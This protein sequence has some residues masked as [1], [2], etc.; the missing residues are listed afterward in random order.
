MKTIK[1][2]AGVA[3]ALVSMTSCND[4]LT[5]SPKDA[6]SPSSTWQTQDDASKFLVGCY[7]GWESSDLLLYLDAGSDYGFNNFSWEGFTNIGNGTFSASDPGWTLYGFGMIRRCNTFLDNVEKCSFSSDAVKNDMIAQAK[8]IRAWRYLKMETAYGGVPIIDNY[9]SADEAKVPRN[10]DQEVRDYIMK[11][12]N[13]ALTGI[14]DQ[15]S[16][17][18]RIAKG[19][20]LAMK[21]RASLYWG[22][23]Q[24]AKD[25][26]QQII[27]LGQY[28]LD[29]NYANVFTVAGQSSP[30]II[31]ACQNITGTYSLYTIGQLYNNGDGGWSSVVPT[32][33]LIDD[34]EMSN[35]L[36]K[37]EA[38]S[39]YDPT[40]PFHNRDPRMAMTV[41]YPGCE[42][43]TT[44][45]SNEVFNTLDEK[46]PNGT[47]NVNYPTYAD[48]ASKTSLT[49]AKYLAPASQYADM[50]DTQCCPIVFRYAEVLLTWAEA[51]NELNGPSTA[52]Y[53]KLDQIRQR[54]G[55]PKVDRAKYGT[56][57]ALRELI[58]RERGVE[59]AGEGIRRFDL[60][61]WKDNNGEMVAMKRL[62]GELKRV[63][64]TINY[65]ESDP[66]MRATITGTAVIENRQFQEYNKLFPIPQSSIDK[67][68]TLTQNPG[69]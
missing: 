29:P 60:V 43:T 37:E 21:M 15:P 17:R 19:A 57:E 47:N 49:W 32:Q 64:G 31:L 58:R 54:V 5:T 13:E 10:T 59:F 20:V 52:V 23:Y 26:A 25:A 63:T 7:D 40:H 66:T 3:V 44:G 69:Y 51:E 9:S 38:G 14:A 6:L 48:N 1:Y 33:N 68:T 67:N 11:N 61:R 12:L 39:G 22:E 4:F 55:M 45:G 65:S 50:W 16:Q 41:L 56:K 62:N 42:W 8:A 24:Q 34:Y 27:D 53:D 30:E 28:S 35:G 36:T 2:I 46:N 18:G